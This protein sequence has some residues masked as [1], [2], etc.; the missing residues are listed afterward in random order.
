M[1]RFLLAILW[2]LPSLAWADDPS[3]ASPAATTVHAGLSGSALVTALRASHYPTT[4]YNYD[5]ARDTLFARVDR[6]AGD[7]LRGAYTGRALWL[8]PSTDPT[9][10]AFNHA[11]NFSTEHSWPQSRGA[12]DGTDGH[13]DMHHLFPV[14]QEVN[15]SRSNLAYADFT[16]ADGTV[17]YGADGTHNTAPADLSGYSARSSGLSRF[18]PRDAVKGDVARALFYFATMHDTHADYAWFEVQ[19]PT[20]L[21]WHAADP[22]DANE[23]ARSN[24]I[25]AYQG[26]D[27][28]FVLDATLAERVFGDG[29]YVITSPRPAVVWIN[30]IHYDNVGADQDEGVEI[31]GTSGGRLDG[32]VLYCYRDDGTIYDQ[33]SL[34]GTLADEGNGHGTVWNAMPGLQNGPADGLALVDPEGTVLHFVSYEGTLTATEGPAAGQTSTDLGQMQ[35]SNTPIGQTLQ[36]TG[37]G[38]QMSDFTWSGPQSASAGT[39]NSGQSFGALPVELVA[40]TAIGTADRIHLTWETASETNNAGFAI[41]WRTARTDWAGMVFVTGYGTTLHAQTY[42]HTLHNLT[43]GTYRVRLRQ[44]DYDG[45]FDYSPEVEAVVQPDAFGLVVSAPS[46]NP[47]AYTAEVVLSASVAG[48]IRVA[49]YDLLGRR[50]YHD[51]RYLRGGEALPYRL[52]VRTWSAGVYLIRMQQ[53]DHIATVRL[54]VAK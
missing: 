25:A 33:T 31:L 29:N 3:P 5:M 34:S 43:P 26:T 41:E 18:E 52:D 17:W 39:V 7:S 1:L 53:H 21:A 4:I 37:T 32:Y 28:P 8:D 42:Q 19:R 6:E 36:L 22:A 2:V 48:D 40:F 51:Q 15:A 13:S 10:Y 24:A 11:L 44:V 54:V 47:A 20:L 50:V 16:R 27:N 35:P 14:M 38:Q 23:I 49:A 45:T 9:T 46:P 30:E 12:V